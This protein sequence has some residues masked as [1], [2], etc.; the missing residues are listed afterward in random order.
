[1]EYSE[2]LRNSSEKFKTQAKTQ[3]SSKKLKNSSKKLKD[4]ANPLGLLAE[5]ASKKKAV[6]TTM[7]GYLILL[8]YETFN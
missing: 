7:K 2:K 6:L 3:N 1:M 4:S 5:N 8:L